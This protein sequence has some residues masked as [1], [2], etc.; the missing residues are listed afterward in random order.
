MKDIV[1][2]LILGIISCSTVIP[3]QDTYYNGEYDLSL[4]YSD[5]IQAYAFRFAVIPGDTMDI[6]IKIKKEDP[7]NFNGKVYA[8]A[9]MPSNMDIQNYGG[10]QINYISENKYN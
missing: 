2:L 1:F 7:F 10:T 4:E 9:Y 8:Y 3:I 5:E 6:E